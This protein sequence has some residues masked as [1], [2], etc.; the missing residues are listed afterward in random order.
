MKSYLFNIQSGGI[1]S[2]LKSVIFT[3]VIRCIGWN[4][5]WH[6]RHTYERPKNKYTYRM[7][8]VNFTMNNY[9]LFSLI[10]RELIDVLAWYNFWMPKL[11]I[12][13]PFC[14]S[15]ICIYR[16]FV[17]ALIQMNMII[18]V[19]TNCHWTISTFIHFRKFHF[20][21]DCL[22]A[23]AAAGM[24]MIYSLIQFAQQNEQ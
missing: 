21:T 6:I 12:I 18:F 15:N 24:H 4:A 11:D 9:D 20:V 8:A 22:L 16:T 13:F 3:A 10:D 2:R 1:D 23:C 17:A 14:T 5:I 7:D 19:D